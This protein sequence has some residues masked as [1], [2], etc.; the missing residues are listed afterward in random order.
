MAYGMM[1]RTAKSINLALYKAIPSKRHS[2]GLHRESISIDWESE[3]VAI[4][5][6]LVSGAHAFR[7]PSRSGSQSKYQSRKKFVI[8]LGAPSSG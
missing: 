7:W 1:V 3:S 2:F 8:V 4:M 6:L 5:L